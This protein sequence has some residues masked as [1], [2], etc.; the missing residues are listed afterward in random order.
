MLEQSCD[1]LNGGQLDRSKLG[2]YIRLVINDVVKEELDV[3]AE[4]G[5]E[6][7]DINKPISDIARKYFF[8]QEKV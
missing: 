2:D 7:K 6:L 4:T 3:I 5:L 8:E 1:L